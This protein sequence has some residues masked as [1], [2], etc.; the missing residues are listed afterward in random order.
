MSHAGH[1][2]RRDAKLL[3]QLDAFNKFLLAAS[4]IRR[5]TAG[6]GREVCTTLGFSRMIFLRADFSSGRAVATSGYGLDT[7]FFSR[8]EEPFEAGPWIFQC[9]RES[10]AAYVPDAAEGPAIPLKYVSRFG[11]GPLL[12][13]PLRDSR[14]P[15]GAMLMD[16]S[17]LSFSASEELMEAAC[18]VGFSVGLALEA[19][20]A[21]VS[22]SDDI[23]G[24]EVVLTP[25]EQQM[26]RLL[27]R[28]LSNKE[29]AAATGLSVFTV[30]D[31][32]SSLLQSL[33]V[34]SRSAAVARAWGLGLPTD[35]QQGRVGSANGSPERHGSVTDHARQM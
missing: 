10:L 28:G 2:V 16:R 21:E 20:A 24:K 13:A 6:L 35:G 19:A 18:A 31:Y 33:D 14:G 17:G 22:Y 9:L 15:V 29:I 7:V 8:I 32:V 27:C 4:P 3:W 25:R 23:E 26:L 12:C 11:I 1:S 34:T 30:R 5:V